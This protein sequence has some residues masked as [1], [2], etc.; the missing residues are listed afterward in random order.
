MP[1]ADW[2][3]FQKNGTDCDD[4]GCHHRAQPAPSAGKS[5][6][7]RAPNHGA[8]AL[9]LALA[10]IG[11][12]AEDRAHILTYTYND[13][14]SLEQAVVEAGDD[15]AGII[16]SAFQHDY[17]QDQHLPTVSFAQAARRDLRQQGMRR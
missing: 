7:P 3:Q 6:W 17:G 9:V 16:V 4:D 8:R 1:H 13:V 11:V 5:L 15:L 2:V 14:A 12:T 10:L